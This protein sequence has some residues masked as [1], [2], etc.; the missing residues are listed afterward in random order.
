MSRWAPAWDSDRYAAAFGE[1]QEHIAAGDTYQVNLT[2]FATAETTVQPFEHFLK[3]SREN[4][5]P[6][7]SFLRVDGVAISSHSPE[8]LLRIVGDRAET[9]PIKGTIA[10]TPNSRVELQASE[11][12]RAEHLMIVDLCRNDLGRRAITGS[13][14]VA[15][16]MEP[17]EVRGIDHLVSRIEA[18]VRPG[19]RSLL[20]PNRFPQR[21]PSTP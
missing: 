9:G 21:V 20:R 19:G 11:K 5:V 17:L 13:V 14:R 3:H 15:G 18:R 10:R 1:V 16:L 2:G 7:A 12:D 6:F 8:R 4:P